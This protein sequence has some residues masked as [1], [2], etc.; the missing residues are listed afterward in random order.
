M[1]RRLFVAVA[2]LEIKQLEPLITVDEQVI[3]A[4][5]D[6]CVA[7]LVN[8]ALCANDFL[9]DAERQKLSRRPS[10]GQHVV[11]ERNHEPRLAKR[12]QRRYARD[13]AV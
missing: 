2:E 6:E 7:S 11:I 13:L 1:L 4:G 3:D 8:L 12:H 10:I 9:R 5:V